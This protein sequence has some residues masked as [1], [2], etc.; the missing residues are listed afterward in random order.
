MLHIL[1]IP[2]ISDRNMVARKG[3]LVLDKKFTPLPVEEGEEFFPNGIF[4]FNVSKILAFIDQNLA[5][6]PVEEVEVQSLTKYGPGN[7]NEDTIK[8]ANLSNPILLA[9][10]SPGHFNLIDGN[11]RVERA[12]RDNLEKIPARRIS[13]DR[14]AA[15][16]TSLK[17]YEAY[18]RYW[19]EKIAET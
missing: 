14:H 7:L 6:F 4:E 15:F 17:A 19:N 13:A 1:K 11:H 3:N 12:R 5:S 16:L 9:E 2:R 8:S 10:I 18:V